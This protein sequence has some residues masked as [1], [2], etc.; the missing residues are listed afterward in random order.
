MTFQ[1]QFL[2]QNPQAEF[3]DNTDATGTSHVAAIRK[4]IQN[5]FDGFIGQ[6]PELIRKAFH[7]NTKLIAI[8]DGAVSELASA[9][10]LSKIEARRQAGV[11]PAAA[12]A[13]IV[14][15]DVAGD[16]AVA[17]VNIKFPTYEF[18]DYLSLLKANEGWVVVNKIYAF[19]E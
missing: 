6:Q 18:V 4:T 12:T 1:T 14:G 15:I 10:W 5:Y 9:E 2:D 16:A 7:Q 3:S 13:T 11:I 17:K 19:F 8:D